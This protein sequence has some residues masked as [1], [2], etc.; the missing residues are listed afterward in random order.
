[1]TGRKTAAA[2]SPYRVDRNHATLPIPQLRMSEQDEVPGA[3]GTQC[4]G[5][6]GTV[7]TIDQG[8]HRPRTDDRA[9]NKTCFT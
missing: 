5:R 6:D 3:F 7:A 2:F 1:M 9:E 4:L 8:E